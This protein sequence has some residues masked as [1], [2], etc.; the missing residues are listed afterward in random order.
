MRLAVVGLGPR[1]R[2]WIALARAHG[3][4]VAAAIDPKRE[5][6]DAASGIGVDPAIVFDTLAAARRDNSVDV[7]I[8]ATAL[9]THITVAR[10]ALAWRRPLLVEKPLA[11][12]FASA[13]AFV[14]E[15]DAAGVPVVVVQNH[16]FVRHWR[17]LRAALRTLPLGIVDG[18]TIRRYRPLPPPSPALEALRDAVLWE[19]IVHDVDA[20][21][22]VLGSELT[23]VQAEVSGVA[24]RPALP[25]TRAT[26]SAA[27]ANGLRMTYEV[28]WDTRGHE[29]FRG[30]D[31]LYVR[32]HAERGTVHMLYGWLI[33]CER[34][35]WPRPLARA[36]RGE[37]GEV[38]LLRQLGADQT[39]STPLLCSARDN[40]RTIAVLEACARSAAE[41]RRVNLADVYPDVS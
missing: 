14:T 6:R 41:G 30:G 9:D 10:E 8:V 12:D 21:R 26:I 5:A 35:R 1:G 39:G 17:S 13:S 16:R 27:L 7:I 32:V 33:Y 38:T 40:L 11:L 36:P 34:G 19:T 18:V 29:F 15:A 2:E 37:L 25:G 24:W 3:H 4:D 28:V 23:W 31:E 22:A 20:V